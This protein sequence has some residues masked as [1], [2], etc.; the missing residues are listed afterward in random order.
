MYVYVLCVLIYC[1]FMGYTGTFCLLHYTQK[2]FCY[3]KSVHILMCLTTVVNVR[4]VVDSVSVKEGVNRTVA[5]WAV[6]EGV[7]A[8]PISIGVACSPVRASDV[9]AGNVLTCLCMH[10]I[11]M[12]VHTYICV[13]NVL[14]V[15]THIR[16][17][18]VLYV[19]TYVCTYVHSLYLCV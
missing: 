11:C 3:H 9:S 18:G 5:L 2:L 8:R 13:Y 16:I 6:S 7:F 14:Y 17:Y 1:F 12:Y 15:Y 4:W 19:C 10:P